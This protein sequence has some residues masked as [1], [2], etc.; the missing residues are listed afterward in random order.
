MR[1]IRDYYVTAIQLNGNNQHRHNIFCADEITAHLVAQ[2]LA[3]HSELWAQIEVMRFTGETLRRY[4]TPVERTSNE[5]IEAYAMA[6][7]DTTT[8][9]EPCQSIAPTRK[10]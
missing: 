5:E 2:T 4:M 8:G 10:Q 1:N 3:Y 7:Q 6:I 9:V